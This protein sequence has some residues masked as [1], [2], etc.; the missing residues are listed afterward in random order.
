MPNLPSFFINF[1]GYWFEVKPE[2][3]LVDHGLGICTICIM[4]RGEDQWILGDTFMR[5]WYS[6]HDYDSNRIGFTPF[7]SSTKQ[8]PELAPT[9]NFIEINKKKER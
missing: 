3:Y 2:D 6:I 5:G 4:S 9:P 8:L 1:G 7:P